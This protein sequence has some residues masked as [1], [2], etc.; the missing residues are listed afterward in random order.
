MN[1]ETSVSSFDQFGAAHL[2]AISI[3]VAVCIALAL[4]TQ[5]LHSVRLNRALCWGIAVELL[6]IELLYYIGAVHEIGWGGFLKLCLPL[7]YCGMSVY[8][9]P[10]ALLTRKQSVY[11]VAY[12]WGLVGATQAILTP[13]IQDGFPSLLFIRFFLTH[14]G[15]VA[16]VIFATFGLGLR[17]RYRGV[18]VTFAL[19]LGF[20]A[21]VGGLNYILD[22]NYMFLRQPPAGASPFFFLDWPWYIGFLS[23]V[24]FAV[25]FLLWLPFGFIERR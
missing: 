24:A 17:P 4:L 2:S 20:A 22:S 10:V 13:A 19:S 14:G 18:W 5:R 11:E 7:H 16:G 8:L 3:T 15:I 25:M 12:F 9:V 6:I 21:V 1:S 23:L